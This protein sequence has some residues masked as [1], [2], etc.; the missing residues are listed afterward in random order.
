MLKFERDSIQMLF[1]L[2]LDH[3]EV[4]LEQLRGKDASPELSISIINTLLS[5]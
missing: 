1:S 5:I 4:I 2:L 3:K